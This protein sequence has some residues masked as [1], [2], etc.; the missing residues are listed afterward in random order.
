MAPS[1]TEHPKANAADEK[2]LREFHR[3]FVAAYN[4][5]D[6]EAVAAYYAPDAD[7]VD[8]KGD[9]HHGR[10]EIEKRTANFF[11]QNKG[12]KLRSPFGTVRFLTP[13]VAI[14][15]RSEELKSPVE[16]L[17]GTLLATVVYVKRDG[18]WLQASVRLMVSFRPSKR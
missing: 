5:G 13:D 3:D 8:I 15:D 1:W 7:F 2:A 18:K 6:S 16:G 10:A 17:P 14:A 12:V 9:R 4:K 11:A